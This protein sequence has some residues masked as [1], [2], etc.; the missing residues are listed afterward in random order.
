MAIEDL[1][2]NWLSRY[3]GIDDC[4]VQDGVGYN[5]HNGV[6]RTGSTADVFNAF[7]LAH[8][9]G[10]DNAII[11]L[12]TT[13]SHIYIINKYQHIKPK[14]VNYVN[15]IEDYCYI[16]CLE[17][18]CPNICEGYDLYSQICEND[19]CNLYELLEANSEVCGYDP[20]EGVVCENICVGLD[21][22]SRK[23]EGGFCVLDQ[24]I[25]SNSSSCGYDP[26][27]GVV[28]DNVCAGLDLWSQK[29]VEGD[30]VPDQLLESNSSS[31][32]YDPLCEG[33][34]CS[35]V[36]YG[37]DLYSSTCVGG[38]CFID[39]LIESNS[40]VCGYNPCE[41]V[42]CDDVCVYERWSQSCDTDTGDCVLDQLIEHN[43]IKCNIPDQV[44]SD[45]STI[46]PYL[47]LGG[48]GLMGLA[49]LMAPKI[50]N[51]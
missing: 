23:C 3:A 15:A 47:I 38:M 50:K 21:L 1:T 41:G 45:E 37:A 51:K 24:L 46:S 42:V 30:C 39:Q 11:I 16:D 17:I 14:D 4:F 49:I 6:P 35:N 2:I 12:G 44:P 9:A 48:F 28:C 27:E 34:V 5:D 29:C 31:C 7:Y 43:L 10:E 32:G 26:C 18:T 20:C 8:K 22:W 13:Y 40:E 19:I 25:E 36:C 33:I